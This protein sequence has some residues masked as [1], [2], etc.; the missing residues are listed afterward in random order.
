[1]SLINQVLRDLEQRQ[2]HPV[3]AADGVL[4]GLEVPVEA[5]RPPARKRSRI[6]YAVVLAVLVPALLLL[7]WA[8]RGAMPR[9]VSADSASSER[10]PEI[11]AAPTP[12]TTASSAAPVSKVTSPAPQAAKLAYLEHG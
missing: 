2:G 9:F 11:V 1:M 7:I 3:A 12:K 10:Q 6:T 8:N 5:P 4:R